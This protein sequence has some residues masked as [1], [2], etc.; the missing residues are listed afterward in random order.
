MRWYAGDAAVPQ[1]IPY[2][3]STLDDPAE[4]RPPVRTSQVP[5]HFVSNFKAGVSSHTTNLSFSAKSGVR[6]LDDGDS[7]LPFFQSC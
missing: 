4:V 5:G 7:S 1:S 2:L 6:S 3:S